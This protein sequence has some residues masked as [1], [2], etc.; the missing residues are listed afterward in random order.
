MSKV[1]MTVKQISDLGLLDK[2]FNYLGINPYALN[3]GQIDYSDTLEFD[4]E[5]KSRKDYL[6]AKLEK[7]KKLLQSIVDTMTE[8]QLHDWNIVQ[9]DG[10]NYNEMIGI[11]TLITHEFTEEDLI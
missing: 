3:E 8:E 4:T 7:Q 9:Y 1:S 6:K 5:F 11:A 10:N 2:V